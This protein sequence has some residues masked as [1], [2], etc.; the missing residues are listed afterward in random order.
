MPV[1]KIGPTDWHTILCRYDGTRLQM[2]VDGV[3]LDEAFPEGL[4]ICRWP[5]PEIQNLDAKKHVWKDTP[6]SSGENLL[7]NVPGELFDLE[8]QV[9]LGGARELGLR[10][11]VTDSTR[12]RAEARCHPA[13][14][15]WLFAGDGGPARPGRS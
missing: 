1:A 9:A 5:V 6:I 14:N 3:L 4:R 8:L 13:G 7:K 12:T 10:P 2:F 15:G 11:T